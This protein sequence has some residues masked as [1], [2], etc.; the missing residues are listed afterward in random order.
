MFFNLL[1]EK[2]VE[3]KNIGKIASQYESPL[4]DIVIWLKQRIYGNIESSWQIF[5]KPTI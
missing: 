2:Y 5:L 3:S 4:L 1:P